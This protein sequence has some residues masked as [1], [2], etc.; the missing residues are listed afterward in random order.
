MLSVK[1]VPAEE[2]NDL[3]DRIEPDIGGGSRFDVE[4]VE[5]FE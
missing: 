1:V 3:I 2:I 5:G 4:G